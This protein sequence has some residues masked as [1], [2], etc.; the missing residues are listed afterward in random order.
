[1]GDRLRMGG[2]RGLITSLGFP[3]WNVLHGGF[4]SLDL[5]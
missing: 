1:M 5:V 2:L 3:Y 4:G